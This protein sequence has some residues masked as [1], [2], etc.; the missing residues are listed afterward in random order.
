MI[1]RYVTV[2]RLASAEFA[3]PASVD[4]TRYVISQRQP[5][6]APMADFGM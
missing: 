5:P 1:K 2:Y 6:L 4:A 3:P